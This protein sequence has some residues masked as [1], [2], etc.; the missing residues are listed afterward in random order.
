MNFWKP[1]YIIVHPS[2]NSLRSQIR[3]EAK[4]GNVI[5]GRANIIYFDFVSEIFKG[6]GLDAKCKL[7]SNA[8]RF[9]LTKRIVEDVK[10]NDGKILSDSFIRAVID[11]IT[12]LQE[13]DISVDAFKKAY[14]SLSD[15][16]DIKTG[17]IADIALFY[18]SYEDH[19]KRR[20]FYDLSDTKK[21]A[22]ECLQKKNC[23]IT[24]L[25][26]V[27]KIIFT[28]IFKITE[29]DFRIILSL[30][31]YMEGK[32]EVIFRL[33]YNPDRQ[34]AF[35]FLENRLRAF[36]SSADDFPALTLHFDYPDDF[37]A[38]L[39]KKSFIARN[40]FKNYSSNHEILYESEKDGI[41][42][43]ESDYPDESLEIFRALNP[44][45]ELDLVLRRI[46]KELQAGTEPSSIALVSAEPAKI[47]EIAR[48]KAE[49]YSIPI[50]Y[51]KGTDMKRVPLVSFLLLIFEVLAYGLYPESA[52]KIL[53]SPFFYYRLFVYAEDGLEV[54]V[55]ADDIDR[56]FSEASLYT[57][58]SDTV[59]RRIEN[60]IKTYEESCDLLN[61]EVQTHNDRMAKREL[62]EKLAFLPKIVAVF[63]ALTK[64]DEKLR[65][66]Q[67]ISSEDL[68][69][70]IREFFKSLCDFLDI[71]SRIISKKSFDDIEGLVFMNENLEALKKFN[72]IMIEASAAFKLIYKSNFDFKTYYELLIYAVE[73]SNLTAGIQH[74]G[75]FFLSP[76]EVIGKDFN[77]VFITG[78]SEGKFPVF[79]AEN[80]L[81][82]DL[83]RKAMASALKIVYRESQATKNRISRLSEDDVKSMDEIVRAFPFVTSKMEYWE[84]AF[85]FLNCITSACEKVELSFSKTDETGV[86][87]AP[88]YYLDQIFSLLGIV[89][90]SA[91]DERRNS[92]IMSP[93]DIISELAQPH[94]NFASRSLFIRNILKERYSEF[95]DRLTIVNE[96]IYQA[97]KRESLPAVDLSFQ[98][99]NGRV[100]R[101][102]KRY[103][104]SELEDY[105]R[106]PFVYFIKYVLKID[107]ASALRKEFNP[108]AAGTII[109]EILQKYFEKMKPG[110]GFVEE[111]FSEV[112]AEVFEKAGI[113]QNMGNSIFFKRNI[114][115]LKASAKNWIISDTSALSFEKTITEK[116]VDL[117]LRVNIRGKREL[118]KICGRIDR[119]DINESSFRI[120]DYKNGSSASN[121]IKSDPSVSLQ[122]PIYYLCVK[123]LYPKLNGTFIY[124]FLKNLR[125]IEPKCFKK[126]KGYGIYDYYFA[127]E[128]EIFS[129]KEKDSFAEKRFFLEDITRVLEGIESGI[130]QPNPY[131][132]DC[133]TCDLKP[134]CRYDSGERREE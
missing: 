49:K 122:A 109:H 34:D 78:L 72:D 4:S 38:G 27:K 50:V 42:I 132:N 102:E 47:A 125:T 73:T 86:A 60:F 89:D 133:G 105:A 61:L 16:A 31:R 69:D 1:D 15:R 99:Y 79:T 29:L 59:L 98:D 65:Q 53:V 129:L 5:S 14:L 46:K 107:R 93:D 113:M 94:S 28:N 103:S 97:N 52:F 101:H 64:F 126:S 57:A 39:S 85:L 19:K 118:R 76:S 55:C 106:C 51:S 3:R 26:G 7:L 35:R 24:I 45:E 74:D 10:K 127:N 67:N 82:D 81:F 111:V 43:Y 117:E 11:L 22:A 68:P 18:A 121:Q 123:S 130:F 70:K 21:A 119:I 110:E 124:A 17:N 83:S 77:I 36:E 41:S 13:A 6:S 54:G 120:V 87:I 131:K 12:E 104:A 32:G 63:Q 90:V 30:A 66:V 100:P 80:P 114:E 25:S 20:K 91:L 44:E 115:R 58:S 23:E 116:S 96:K 112:F 33:P 84:Q 8:S 48:D 2:V 62:E 75:I 40:I 71:E 56:L 134:L 95:Y 88:S 92:D 108:L 128:E 9:L 37:F